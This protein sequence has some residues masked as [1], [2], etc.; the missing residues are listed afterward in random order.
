[1]LPQ[2][3]SHVHSALTLLRRGR[4]L[5]AVTVLQRSSEDPQRFKNKDTLDPAVLSD[6]LQRIGRNV[7]AESIARRFLPK[8]GDTVASARLHFALGNIERERGRIPNAIEHFQIATATSADDQELCCWSQLRLM[9]SIGELRGREAAM[10]RMEEVKRV[11]TKY[12]DARPFAALHLWFVESDAM[13]GYLDNAQR[14]LKTADSL[15]LQIDDV[16]LKGYLAINR[17][18]VNY[19]CAEIDEARRSAQ[20]AITYA[21]QSGHRTTKRA[22]HANLGYFDFAIGEFGSAELH[23][24]TALDCCERGSANEIAILDNIAETKLEQGDLD[25]CRVV[26][27]QLE[28]LASNNADENRRHYNAWTLQTKIRLMLREGR[29]TEAK[30]VCKRLQPLVEGL[31][32]A[33]VTVETQILT[34]QVFSETQGPVAVN[35]LTPILCPAVPLAPDLFAEG[36]LVTGK[37]LA[38]S[39]I[40]LAK[41]H[42]ERA[43]Q[44][45]RTI[46]HSL[47]GN[48]ALRQLRELRTSSDEEQRSIE[49]RLIDRFRALFELRTRAELFA[50]EAA[51][52]IIDSKCASNVQVIDGLRA[53]LCS[54]REPSTGGTKT[55]PNSTLSILVG[56]DIGKKVTVAFT[57]FNDPT[58]QLTAL[59]LKRVLQQIL[60]NQSTDYP[61]RGSDIVWT[62]T[63]GVSSAQDVVFASSAM[64]EVWRTVTQIAATNV[65]V[66]VTGETGSGKEVIARSI[67]A[68]SRRAH[69][70]FLALNCAAVPK[71]LIE[72][73]LFGHRKGA[74]SGAAENHPGIVRAANG[75]TLL[76]DEI[77]EL[78]LDLQAKL[79]RFLEMSEVHPVGEAHPV[80]VN[81]RLIFATNGDLEEAVNQNRF[82][83]DLYYRLNVIPIKVPP[84]RERR[85]EIPVL[86]NL[87]AQRFA[88]EFGKDAVRFSSAAME[89][90]ILCSWPGNIRQLANEVRRLAALTESGACITPDDLSP[91]LRPQG[92]RDTAPVANGPQLQVSI[93]QP[94]DKATAQLESE[95]IKHAL[96][97]AGGRVSDA[98]STLGISRKGLYLKRMRLGLTD[99]GERAH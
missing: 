85:E 71:D 88:A 60:A 59:S 62:S 81:V 17:S 48:R 24:Q 56:A 22:A 58:S 30:E 53:E 78:P 14:H 79:L 28:A 16:W 65:S 90:L 15:L 97:Q 10:S 98:A 94:L 45:F 95:M 19:Y 39:A 80:K 44:T 68:R 23:F 11:L 33:R 25:G 76:L 89:Q 99:F 82:R 5:E 3:S 18:V 47:G 32:Q 35:H 40:D 91:Q 92:G 27:T 49:G 43:V 73:Q 67:H 51:S 6:A 41:A 26:L 77:G 52:L 12:G 20:L 34:A 96:K 29:N 93:D 38:V 46:G 72:S 66:L 69:M 2:P 42:L 37:L 86:A 4:F 8:C 7:E 31:P 87:F 21:D 84:L 36:E 74:F 64:L 61:T 70:P 75:G 57:P 1:M 54:V 50:Y 63:D 9:T 13:S 83:Q 55:T